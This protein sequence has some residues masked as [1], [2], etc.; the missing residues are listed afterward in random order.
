MA[1]IGATLLTGCTVVVSLPASGSSSSN[2][3]GCVQLRSEFP[4]LAIL[5]LSEL[6]DLVKEYGPDVDALLLAAAL[7]LGE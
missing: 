6:E 7:L 5:T 3:S 4:M 2:C 1:L